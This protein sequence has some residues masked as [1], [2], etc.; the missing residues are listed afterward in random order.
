MD[1]MIATSSIDGS[2][3]ELTFDGINPFEIGAP[4]IDQI[5]DSVVTEININNTNSNIDEL[6]A[7]APST[8]TYDIIG[9]TV[10]KSINDEHFIQD[11][12]V[13]ELEL[14]FVLPLHLKTSGYALSDTIDFELFGEDG[15]DPE[16]IKFL[17]I[18]V[19]T[20]N[21]L[22]IEFELQLYFT[23]QNYIVLDSLFDKDVRP[24]V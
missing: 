21:G 8:I 22:P 1:N 23:D 18:D 4:S 7:S 12:S 14:E 11:R 5:G 24:Q 13:M 9:R 19:G 10:Y 6:L 15:I 16:M 2:T 20:D 17:Q 3:M